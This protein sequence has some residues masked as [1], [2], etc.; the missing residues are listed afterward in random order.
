MR[1]MKAHTV[2]WMKGASGAPGRLGLAALLL[3][4]A[5]LPTVA[6]E[7]LEV[8]SP[9]E[10]VSVSFEIVEVCPPTR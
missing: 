1:E 9:G 8:A 2:A 3:T 7:P 4:F 6:Q 10:V 5:A